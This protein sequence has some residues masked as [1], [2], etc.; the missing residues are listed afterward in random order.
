VT[1]GLQAEMARCNVIFTLI[2]HVLKKDFRLMELFLASGA[3]MVLQ[4]GRE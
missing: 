2:N 1:A 3:K 4:R